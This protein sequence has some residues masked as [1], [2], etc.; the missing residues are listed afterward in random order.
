MR[1]GEGIL[2]ALDHFGRE[3]R[4]LYV[5]MRDVQGCAEDFT[6][7]FIDEGNSDVAV[8]LKKLKE[9]GFHGFILDDHV[10][11]MVNDSAWGH[12]G[13]AFATGYIAGILAALDAA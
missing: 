3:G 12:R 2:E 6:E 11:C 7:C 13:R 9:V 5:H 4:I 8:V 1:A 10:P